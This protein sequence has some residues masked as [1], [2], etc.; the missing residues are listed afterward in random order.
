MAD[1]SS[2]GDTILP[3]K[4]VIVEGKCFLDDCLSALIAPEQQSIQVVERFFL[5][6]YLDVFYF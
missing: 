6:V 1:D 5:L 4:L 2:N 3:R